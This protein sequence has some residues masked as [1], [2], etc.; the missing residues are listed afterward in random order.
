MCENSLSVA[1]VKS[2]HAKVKEEEV[3]NLIYLQMVVLDVP[4]NEKKKVQLEKD[5]CMMECHGVLTKLCSL[6]DEIMVRKCW[7]GP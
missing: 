4:K 7:N 3:P 2:V 1:I 6:C 5:L